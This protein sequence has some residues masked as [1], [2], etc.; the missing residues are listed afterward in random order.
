VKGH[1]VNYLFTDLIPDLRAAGIDDNTI[2]RIFVDNPATFL[3]L[4][5]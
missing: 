3:S 2:T 4:S 5:T 1:T